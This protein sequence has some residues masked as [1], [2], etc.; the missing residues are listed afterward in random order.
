MESVFQNKP[1]KEVE[2]LVGRVIQANTIDRE[3]YEKQGF[4][5]ALRDINGKG[6]PIGL[7]SISEIVGQKFDGNAHTPCE[8]ELYYRGYSIGDILKGIPLSSHFGY[9]ECAYLLLV[10]DLPTEKELKTFKKQLSSLRTLPV[11]FTTDIILRMPSKDM[12]NTL[13]RCVL[14]LYPY[15]DNPD[16]TSIPNVLRQSLQLMSLFPILSVYAY[17]AYMHYHEGKT[18]YL[19]NPRPELSTA[20]NL[21]YTLRADN[22]YS[23][24]EAKLLDTVLILHMEHGGGNN[25]TFA[26]R[27]TSTSGT[28]T[29]SAIAAALGS[30]KGPKHGGATPKVSEMIEDIKKNVSDWKDEDAIADYI[31]KLL[32]GKAFDKT[33]H[34]YGMGHAVYS[35]SDPRA[36]IMRRFCEMLSREKGLEDEFALYTLVEK[37][38]TEVISKNC[39]I[40]KGVCANLE[41]FSGF[42]Y[43]MLNLPEE[44]YTPIFAV[45]R[46]AGWSAHRLESLVGNGKIVR[47]SYSYVHPRREFVPIENR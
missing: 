46:I 7:T 33:G 22:S 19:H 36:K 16:D 25:S 26:A 3:L 10:G 38:A 13:A 45:A 43:K 1:S 8:G 11:N 24:L 20:E 4:S 6:L 2:E 28:D 17:L 29:Y 35:L 42:A 39:T 40:Y 32:D 41:F 34:I 15:D 18:L 9:E 30:L 23:P 21:L 31:E 47:P 5:K 44:L 14:A 37:K 27:M 12:M